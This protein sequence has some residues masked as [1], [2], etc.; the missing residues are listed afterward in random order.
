MRWHSLGRANPVDLTLHGA[1]INIII[2]IV[3]VV[4]VVVV[5]IIIIIIVIRFGA[6]LPFAR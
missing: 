4:V 1:G 3:V 5:A 2:I 6:V